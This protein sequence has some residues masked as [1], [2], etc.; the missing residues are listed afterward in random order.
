MKMDFM[1]NS[2]ERMFRKSYVS[3]WKRCNMNILK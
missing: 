3:R 2:E 1:E